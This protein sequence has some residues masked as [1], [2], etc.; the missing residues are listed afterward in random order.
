VRNGSDSPSVEAYSGRGKIDIS[1][2]LLHAVNFHQA[3]KASTP[4][5]T[6]VAK[7]RIFA[8][9]PFTKDSNA[10]IATV[11]SPKEAM[12]IDSEIL[13]PLIT[14]R[15][16]RHKM[17]KPSHEN[18][19][20]QLRHRISG[21]PM[22]EAPWLGFFNM[23][24]KT[25]PAR[26]KDVA[27]PKYMP[28]SPT[29][30]N[31]AGPNA[32][33][34][35]D[36]S[37]FKFTFSRSSLQLSPEALKLMEET[38]A[39]ATRIRRQ[40]IAQREE[41][42]ANGID[43]RKIALPKSKTS[44]FSDVHMA[45]FKKMDSIANH[46]SLWRANNSQPKSTNGPSLKRS[47]SKADLDK[48]TVS[49]GLKRSPSK[50]NLYQP[51]TVPSLKRSPSKADL[52][53]LGS[54]VKPAGVSKSPF[55]SLPIPSDTEHSAKRARFTVK[56]D[57]STVSTMP[58]SPQR[59]P[60]GRASQSITPTPMRSN[61]FTPTKASLAR[62]QSVKASKGSKIPGLI[63]SNS[64][65]DLNEKSQISQKYGN[66]VTSIRSDAPSPSPVKTAFP[67]E[68]P[69]SSSIRLISFKRGA[70]TSHRSAIPTPS[71]AIKSILRTPNRLYS[72]DPSKIAAGTHLATPP[73]L[74]KITFPAIP[75]TAPV[76]K[77]VDFT[78]SAREK[79]ARD[80]AKADSAEPETSLYPDISMHLTSDEDE[81]QTHRMAFSAPPKKAY[82]S[83]DFTF[84]VGMPMN[85]P[86]T[87]P[88][89]RAV[90]ASD[91]EM[92]LAPPAVTSVPLGR[93]TTP[94]RKVDDMLDAVTEET[95]N[96]ENIC[97]GDINMD[98]DDDSR[99]TKRARM[100][101]FSSVQSNKIVTDTKTTHVTGTKKKNAT[102]L[103]KGRIGGLRADRL[104]F[105]ARPKTR[106]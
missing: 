27:L 55:T 22:D 8:E 3:D 23:Q 80:E 73:D 36:K 5:P 13:S 72:N 51:T 34:S 60:D 96:K 86:P 66:N 82:Q 20:P 78:A 42:R 62:A 30:K 19:H 71:K 28:V 17:P 95:G 26:A 10:S 47:P 89:I 104:A 91:A 101:G 68:I 24:P 7:A 57:V 59:Q 87:S 50:A 25:E 77:R 83:N 49:R 45:E 33:N 102:V 63:R 79:A 46:S 4:K 18:M 15:T 12:E 81:P 38:R 31:L 40:M 61:L 1:A 2:L 21:T 43:D 94:K 32:S 93:A 29:P 44:R 37:N 98:D 14:Q 90:R 76:V 9:K 75:A 88:T 35:L 100:A 41:D 97:G 39:E 67:Q 64:T 65:M 58:Y 74:T 53:K 16:P 85:F 105:L 99:P 69:K 70:A 103:R 92:S 54:A 52:I 56:D 106:K 6:R 48:P 84:R 11:V